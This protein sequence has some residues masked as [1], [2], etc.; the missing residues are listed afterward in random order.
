LSG[1]NAVDEPGDRMGADR[2]GADRIGADPRG[3][4]VGSGSGGSGS[5]GSGRGSGSGGGSGD[6]GSGSGGSGSGSGSGGSCGGVDGVDGGGGRALALHS[7]PLHEHPAM[8]FEIFGAVTGARAAG[9]DGG[10]DAGAFSDSSVKVGFDVGDIDENSIDNI[11]N[12]AP[13]GGGGALF[14]MMFGALVIGTGS[15]QHDPTVA[16]GDLAMGKPA[17]IIEPAGLLGKAKGFAKP[18]ERFYAVFIGKHGDDRGIAGHVFLLK[19]IKKPARKERAVCFAG[20]RRSP[21]TGSRGGP[22]GRDDNDGNGGSN[23]SGGGNGG[24]ETNNDNA[25]V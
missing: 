22:G 17:G 15:G 9:F 12:G 14:A 16:E 23:G 18:F 6:S 24:S 7:G 10:E 21:A 3:N 5:G 19:V 2:M 8:A 20:R 25:R 4:V 11:R 1:A 13:F